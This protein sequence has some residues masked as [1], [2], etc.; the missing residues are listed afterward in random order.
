[1]R[2]LKREI[3]LAQSLG[4]C[5]AICG[6]N[7]NLAALS[8][9]HAAEKRFKLDTRSLSNPTIE[10]VLK[11]FETCELLCLNCHAELHS[12]HLDLKLINAEE[13]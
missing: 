12:P 3:E 7:K 9:H 11:E 1:M 2:G 10:K 4:G 13:L 6:Y 8:F 5:C